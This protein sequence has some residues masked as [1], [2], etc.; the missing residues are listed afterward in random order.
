MMGVVM[1]ETCWASNKICN[2]KP[3]LHLVGILFP[4]INDDAWSK[5]HQRKN[6]CCK[7]QWPISKDLY[8]QT[9]VPDII[10]A[11]LKML[12]LWFEKYYPEHEDPRRQNIWMW[13]LLFGPGPLSYKKRICRAVVSQRLRNTALGCE[14]SE[15]SITTRPFLEATL[16]ARAGGFRFTRHL[17]KPQGF[18]GRSVSIDGGWIGVRVRFLCYSLADV[19]KSHSEQFLNITVGTCVCCMLG[20]IL[21]CGSS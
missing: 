11:H 19:Y 6:M 15:L 16:C 14:N 4:H 2:K 8:S 1:P 21:K 5:S 18:S 7:C 13:T 12:L 10:A 20:R 9:S 17:S 3:L